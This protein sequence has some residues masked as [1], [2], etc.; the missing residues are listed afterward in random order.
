VAML[1]FDIGALQEQ[2]ARVDGFL[3]RDDAVWQEGD[4]RPETAVHATGRLSSA[5]SGRYYWSGR[6]EGV[7]EGACRRCLTGLSAPVREDVHFIF[8]ETDDAEA[9][10]PDV[11]ALPA[12]AHSVDLRP[13]IREQWLLSAPTFALCREDCKG[14]CPKCGADLN[15]ADCTCEPE[16]DSR[17]EALRNLRGEA[18]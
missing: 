6:I 2:A 7:V 1:S 5:G 18:R 9:E 8:V 17:W 13:A 12:S 14:L 15:T 11:F 4:P 16:V 10:D 3:S